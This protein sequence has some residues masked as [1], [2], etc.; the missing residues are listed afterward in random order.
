MQMKLRDFKNWINK[1]SED[2]L[3][4]DLM[5]NSID[6]GISGNVNE[7]MR[8]DNDLYYVGDEPVLLHTR[9]ELLKRGF[10]D[11]QIAQFE[12]EIPEGCYYIEISNEYSILE[13]FLQ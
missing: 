13:R 12:V 10:T 1:L 7:I 2:E 6:Y 3:D 8:S 9:D 4:K 5:Y 11:A